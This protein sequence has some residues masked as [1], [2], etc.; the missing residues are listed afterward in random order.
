MTV[1]PASRRP[2]LPVRQA[3]L[4]LSRRG[5]QPL[6][7]T[8]KGLCPPSPAAL[9]LGNACHFSHLASEDD[10][11]SSYMF[12]FFQHSSRTHLIIACGFPSTHYPEKLPLETSLFHVG[13]SRRKLPKV[14][15]HAA[16]SSLPPTS[17]LST[18]TNTAAMDMLEEVQPRV[19]TTPQK[20][21][22][23]RSCP[24]GSSRCPDLSITCPVGAPQME[25]EEPY[26]YKQF[27]FC[28]S[29]LPLGCTM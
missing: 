11:A 22:L 8:K 12:L 6:P 2:S 7:P 21:H 15:Q 5:D 29:P 24:L 13:L 1:C 26:I 14:T 16:L 17:P 27:P 18:N 19:C 20:V 10:A 4:A 3:P 9:A 25:L 23:T 28:G